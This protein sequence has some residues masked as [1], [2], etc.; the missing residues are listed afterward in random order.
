[1][2]WPPGLTADQLY[3]NIEQMGEHLR[4]EHPIGM[5][6]GLQDHTAP[7]RQEQVRPEC[8]RTYGGLVNPPIPR[9][10]IG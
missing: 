1:M 4:G 10:S 6:V 3:F 2:A 5:D 8:V 7:G 9:P